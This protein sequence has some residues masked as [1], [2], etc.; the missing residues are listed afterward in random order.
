MN[1]RRCA[2]STSAPSITHSRRELVNPGVKVASTAHS[3]HHR[4]GAAVPRHSGS[5][6]GCAYSITP[7]YFQSGLRTGRMVAARLSPNSSSRPYRLLFCIPTS[8]CQLLHYPEYWETSL[9]IFWK[10]A[11]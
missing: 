4:P 7:R 9:T 10:I 1:S 3:H 6:L 2:W 5:A 11:V 8:E